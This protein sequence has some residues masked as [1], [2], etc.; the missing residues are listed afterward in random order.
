MARDRI[1]DD[2]LFRELRIS[3]LNRGI[4]AY[5]L[6]SSG[7]A[8]TEETNKEFFSCPLCQRTLVGFTNVGLPLEYEISSHLHFVHFVD[9][10]A[11]ELEWPRWEEQIL[12]AAMDTAFR[13]VD[14][15]VDWVDRWRANQVSQV[16]YANWQPEPE[17]PDQTESK[18]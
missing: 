4:A 13:V 1:I 17:Q 6:R 9:L 7:W 14:S 10:G 5:S 3:Q 18:K 2:A 11:G 16:W 15:E 8:A 12:K